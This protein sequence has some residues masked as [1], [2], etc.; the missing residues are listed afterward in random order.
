MSDAFFP[1]KSQTI[2]SLGPC[3]YLNSVQICIFQ[4]HQKE[5]PKQFSRPIPASRP[6]SLPLLSVV[7]PH[8]TTFSE[9]A[10]I[11]FQPISGTSSDQTPPAQHRFQPELA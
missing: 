4:T 7:V 3:L 2:D 9:L 1:H 5:T 11:Y 8:G 10:H 6:N